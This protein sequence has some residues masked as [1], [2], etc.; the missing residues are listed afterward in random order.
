MADAEAEAAFLNSMRAGNNTDGNYEHDGSVNGQ[1]A[2]SFS[3]EEYEPAQAVPNTSFLPDSREFAEQTSSPL[4]MKHDLL[5]STSVAH[6]I[7]VTKSSI[8]IPGQDQSESFPA[9]LTES[10]S[11][12]TTSLP[13]AT[14]NSLPGTPQNPVETMGDNAHQLATS[15]YPSS[16]G[17]VH[18]TDLN[19][20]LSSV[21]SSVAKH[22]STLGAVPLQNAAS[23]RYASE[24]AQK[25]VTGSATK[26]TVTTTNNDAVLDDS[27]PITIQDTLAPEAEQTGDPAAEQIQTPST[28]ALKARLPHDKIGILED[29]IKEDPRG[30]LDAWLSLIG[31]HRK[32][33]KLLDARNTYERF[34]KVIPTAVSIQPSLLFKDT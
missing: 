6:Q 29:R 21:S 7:N 9:A 32:R 13:S 26:L 3:T 4:D 27:T 34:L 1:K 2:E 18:P 31:E 14:A 11:M 12:S 30:D 20:A 5:P 33:G 16:N 24:L 28:A 17:I 8:P 19:D 23:Y 22:A 25:S 10:R 15:T